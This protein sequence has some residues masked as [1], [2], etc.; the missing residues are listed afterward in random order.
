MDTTAIVKKTQ[1]PGFT[2]VEMIVV[3]AIIGVITAITITGQ[4]TFN[5]S[6]LLTDT[7]YTVAFSA[8]QAQ[9]FG[10]SSR[11]FG[12]VANVGYGLRFDRSTPTTYLLFADSTRSLPTPAVCPVGISGTPEQKPGNCRFDASTD[13]IVE[14]YSFSRGFSISGFCG[15]ASGQRYCSTDSTP[16]T[17]LDVVYARPNPAATMT[18]TVGNTTIS[19]SCVEVYITDPERA[20]TRTIRL[21]N[22]GEISLNQVCS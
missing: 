20:A 22:L 2:I 10:L 9:S 19:F 7:A 17:T 11:S 6:L 3:V 1:Q 15:R 5:R 18:G 21:S 12:S 13:G 8:R 14:R 16:V 4:S